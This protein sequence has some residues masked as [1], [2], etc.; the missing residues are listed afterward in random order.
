MLIMSDIRKHNDNLITISED[1][2]EEELIK[3]IRGFP[4]QLDN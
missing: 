4:T 1:I 2:E 3:N